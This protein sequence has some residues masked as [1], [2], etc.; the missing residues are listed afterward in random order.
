MAADMPTQPDLTDGWIEWAGGPVPVDGTGAWGLI[1][2]KGETR[3]HASER[4][5][6][7]LEFWPWFGEDEQPDVVAY[8][9]VEQGQ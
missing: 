5:L 1:Q 7:C 4:R 3:Q 2:F 9:V 6:S 8:R